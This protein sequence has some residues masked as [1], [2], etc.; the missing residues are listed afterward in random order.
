MFVA[1]KPFEQMHR[2]DHFIFEHPYLG[3]N[4]VVG[5]SLHSQVFLDLKDPCVVGICCRSVK[6]GFAREPTSWLTNHP[7]LAEELTNWRENVS[8]REPARHVQVKS[9]LASAWYLV[10]LVE[11]FLRVVLEDLRGDKEPSTVA[12][13][14]AGPSQH[15]GCGR[16]GA[17]SSQGVEGAKAR[18][19]VA[20]QTDK[21]DADRPNYRSRLLV[22]EIKRA[23]KKSDVPCAAELFSGMPP[24]ENVLFVANT[25]E[26]AKSKLSLAMYDISLA[27]FHG[28]PVRRVFVELPK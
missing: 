10:E 2:G 26:E 23:M 16:L 5:S 20:S 9:G 3:K 11:S 22:R 17:R 18:P 21:V 7:H 4:C 1:H 27:H 13:F 28:V 15:E 8:G 12:A 6:S 25:Q 14:S 24:L 19:C